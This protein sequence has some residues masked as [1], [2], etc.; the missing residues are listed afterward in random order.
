MTRRDVT[1][2]V[3]AYTVAIVGVAA[4]VVIIGG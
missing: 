4:A 2:L 3:L 1:W